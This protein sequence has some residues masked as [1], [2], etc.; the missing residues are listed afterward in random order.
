MRGL[1]GACPYSK[2]MADSGRI[3]LTTSISPSQF[4][5]TYECFRYCRHNFPQVI[6]R[7]LTQYS[8]DLPNWDEAC[9]SQAFDGSLPWRTIIL[10]TRSFHGLPPWGMHAL[11][12]HLLHIHDY[13][14]N[15][16]GPRQPTC[17]S[18]M[19]NACHNI[20]LPQAQKRSEQQEAGSVNA[21]K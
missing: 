17:S 4:C 1:C 20:G 3:T 19:Y 10:H 8:K 2:T 14:R 13:S 18:P 5:R 9:Y 12:S 6:T 7:R 15:I 16:V 11:P 21:F